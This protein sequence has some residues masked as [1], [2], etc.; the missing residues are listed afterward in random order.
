MQFD[1]KTVNKLLGINE[2]YKAPEKMLE[3]MLD[4]QQ[5]PKLFKQFLSISTDMHFDWFHEYFED[6]QAERKSKKQDFT[7]DSVATILNRLASGRQP[8]G[9]YFEVAA[10]TG[11]ILINRWWQDCVDDP[12]GNPIED[13][14]G[15]W[16]SIFTYDPR[17]YWYQVEEMSDRAIPFLIFNMAIRGMNGAIVHGDSLSRKAKDVYFIRNDTDNCL[18]FSEVHRMQHTEELAKMYDIHEWVDQL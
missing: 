8:T 18:A 7:P 17:R 15:A 5:R 4:D 16:L 6:E 2:S 13:E 3:I 11:G 10:G 14:Q 1:T 9:T 12:V